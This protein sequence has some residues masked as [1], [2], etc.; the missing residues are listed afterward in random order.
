MV[1]GMRLTGGTAFVSLGK[2]IYPMLGTDS[3]HEDRKSSQ[4]D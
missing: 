3:I 2:K 1:T 4:H